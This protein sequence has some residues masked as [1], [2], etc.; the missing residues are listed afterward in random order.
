MILLRGTTFLSRCAILPVA[1]SLRYPYKKALRYM[2][3]ARLKGTLDFHLPLAFPAMVF[4][5]TQS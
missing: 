1:L 2:A 4:A 5:Y 3:N